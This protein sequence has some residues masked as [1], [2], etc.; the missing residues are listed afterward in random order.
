MNVF[1]DN[2]SKLHKVRYDVIEKYL[3]KIKYVEVQMLILLMKKM[4]LLITNFWEYLMILKITFTPTC[5]CVV[6]FVR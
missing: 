6:H 4:L 3:T 1:K 5:I 2:L